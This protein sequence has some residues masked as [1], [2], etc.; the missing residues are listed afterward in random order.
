MDRYTDFVSDEPLEI[1]RANE[2]ESQVGSLSTKR[3][4][5]LWN[6]IVDLRAQLAERDASP[7]PIYSTTEGPKETFQGKRKG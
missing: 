2:C 1:I 3:F 4:R 7:I 5:R 6:E